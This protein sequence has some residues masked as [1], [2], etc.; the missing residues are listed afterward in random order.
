[1][2][3]SAL[4]F[5]SQPHLVLPYMLCW[6]EAVALSGGGVLV[7]LMQRDPCEG[8]GRKAAT[9]DAKGDCLW[10]KEG[11]ERSAWSSTRWDNHTSRNMLLFWFQKKTKE[12]LT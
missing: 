8:T 12:N 7:L 3:G 6:R 4:V 1:M 2:W 10:R 5:F 11:W 9:K